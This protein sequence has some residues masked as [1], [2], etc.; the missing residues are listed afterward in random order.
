MTGDRV[1]HSAEPVRLEVSAE[2]ASSLADDAP[3]DIRMRIALGEAT[4]PPG[5]LSAA[6]YYL[7]HDTD[8]EIRSAAM[9]TIRRLDPERIL[10]EL[11]SVDLHPAILEIFGRLHV[12]NKELAE[13]IALHPS[14]GL[15]TLEFLAAHG[16]E[17]AVYACAA[18]SAIEEAEPDRPMN[19]GMDEEGDEESVE[20]EEFLSKYQQAQTMGVA[21]K[22][23]TALTGDKEWRSILIKD[24]NKMVSGAVI[25]N[26]R[27]TDSEVLNIAKSAVQN[28]E[29]IRSI[30]GNKEWVKIYPIRKALVENSKTP[31]SFS[32]RFMASLTEK[33]LAAL[34]KSKNVSS[35]I[36][37]QARRVLL[38]M[39]KHS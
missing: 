39:K 10:A 24:S 34:S 1:S 28:D 6:L 12:R 5:D 4:L 35:V 11:S 18:A 16:I 32:L 38:N 15:D 19:V 37:S 8:A 27:I 25:K 29:I 31:L 13:Q 7:C 17:S 14:T 23:K 22:V 9:Q 21:E 3:Q 20:E 2:T 26:P 33:D 30:C 36:V